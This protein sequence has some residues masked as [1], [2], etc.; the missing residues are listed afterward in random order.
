MEL[1]FF[2]HEE[3]LRAYNCSDINFNSSTM[4]QKSHQFMPE[5]IVSILLCAIYYASFSCYNIDISNLH[6]QIGVDFVYS[7]HVL[8]VETFALQSLLP[9]PLLHW[10]HGFGHSVDPWLPSCVAQFDRLHVLQL[11]K[12]DLFHRG[13]G[14]KFVWQLAQLFPN[15]FP[16][17]WRGESAGDLVGKHEYINF[18]SHI[19]SIPSCWP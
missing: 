6:P 7:L 1:Y 3:Y 4:L 17:I 5:S 8:N 15:Y 14:F 19:Q 9:A 13:F 10:H 18:L 16:G 11:S 2:R 12:F